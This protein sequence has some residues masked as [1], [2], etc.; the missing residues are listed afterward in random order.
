MNHFFSILLYNIAFLAIAFVI[1]VLLSGSFLFFKRLTFNKWVFK[2]R[3]VPLKYNQVRIRRFAARF[4]LYGELIPGVSFLCIFL[5]ILNYSN[6]PFIAFFFYAI[7]L[8]FIIT[9]L[10]NVGTLFTSRIVPSISNC[11]LFLRPFELEALSISDGDSKRVK[12]YSEI[13]GEICKYLSQHVSQVFSIGNPQGMVDNIMH[14]VSIYASDEEWRD[15][16]AILAKK[17]HVIVVHVGETNGCIWEI[18]HCFEQCL[19]DKVLFI[20]DSPNKLYFLKEHGILSESEDFFGAGMLVYRNLKKDE[21]CFKHIDDINKADEEIETIMRDYFSSRES[22]TVKKTFL[23]SSNENQNLDSVQKL[24]NPGDAVLTVEKPWVHRLSFLFCPFGYCIANKWSE[25]PMLRVLSSLFF[26]Y[27]FLFIVGVF[28]LGKVFCN[29]AYAIVCFV[30][31][32]WMIICPRI[33]SKEKEYSPDKMSEILSVE[34]LKK[35]II[36]FAVLFLALALF[37]WLHSFG[38]RLFDI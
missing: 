29:I 30:L 31:A 1:W 10:G 27:L 25:S 2:K 15:V 20:V 32:C 16:I 13:S 33:T 9:F 23:D 22:I 17:A 3:D 26:A 19:F 36:S 14:S 37:T 28:G 21:W 8:T 12:I 4:E 18:E 24:N 35:S 5:S 34:F 11:C 7:L 38:L 6:L